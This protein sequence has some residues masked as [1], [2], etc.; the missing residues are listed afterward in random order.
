MISHASHATEPASQLTPVVTVTG[1]AAMPFQGQEMRSAR[2]VPELARALRQL[3]CCVDLPSTHAEFSCDSDELHGAAAF[4]PQGASNPLQAHNPWVELGRL[5]SDFRVEFADQPGLNSEAQCGPEEAALARFGGLAV[6]QGTDDAQGFAHRVLQAARAQAFVR[7][8]YGLVLCGGQSRRMMRDKALLSFAD[9]C[10]Q[11]ERSVALL[12]ECCEA[13]FCSARSEQ[14]EA[15]HDLCGAPV[16][17]DSVLGAGPLGGILSAMRAHPAAAWLVVAVD[18]PRLDGLCLQTLL[19]S[20][21]P[22]RFATVYRSLCTRYLEPLCAIYEPKFLPA[23]LAALGL[24]QT[25]PGRVLA[26]LRIA[27]VEQPDASSALDNVNTPEDYEHVRRD[28]L[29]GFVTGESQP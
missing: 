13:V 3:G 2:F 28:M 11:L 19:A 23:G 1:P 21:D 5:T 14:A 22:L 7:P 27:E 6:S 29:K 24:G 17:P 4:A 15:Y 10:T 16:I 20:R 26:N 25:C 8:L 12:S 9:G 18:L